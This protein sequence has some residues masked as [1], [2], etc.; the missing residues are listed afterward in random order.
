LFIAYTNLKLQNP[1]IYS[2]LMPPCGKSGVHTVT[3]DLPCSITEYNRTQMPKSHN[4]NYPMQL[5]L[6][7]QKEH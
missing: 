2:I 4:C 6:S 7:Y 3:P 1:A 5:I